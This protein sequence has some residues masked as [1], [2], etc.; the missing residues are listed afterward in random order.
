MV[1]GCY[2]LAARSGPNDQNM[3]KML[4]PGLAWRWK[5]ASPVIKNR[6]RWLLRKNSNM[7][8]ELD[9]EM[10]VAIRSLRLENQEIAKKKKE[11]EE[12]KECAKLQPP[13]YSD[14]SGE[15]GSES[16]V[17]NGSRK[18]GNSCNLSG[19]CSSPEKMETQTSRKS[20]TIE[21]K[22]MVAHANIILGQEKL[23]LDLL[24]A[25]DADAEAERQMSQETHSHDIVD[26]YDGL[27]DVLRETQQND[28]Q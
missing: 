2:Q 17:S 25:S 14:E 6:V 10:A 26:I 4:P 24:E 1:A 9:I 15:D 19:C 3:E 7:E 13:T 8:D 28:T 23:D 21:T 12:E 11:E 18:S 20:K 27:D 22:D 5:H 16:T